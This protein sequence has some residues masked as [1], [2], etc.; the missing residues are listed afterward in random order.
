MTLERIT[1]DMVWDEHDHR[2]RYH[3][4]AGLI[5]PND[6]V[7]DAAC[8]I[9]YGTSILA[10]RSR[11]AYFVGVDKVD[12]D[13]EFEGPH[14][15]FVLADLESD[16]RNVAVDLAGEFDVSVSFETIEHLRDPA[17]FIA[18]L[19]SVTTRTIVAS[20]PVVPSKHWNEHH[21]HDFERN[22]LPELFAVNGWECVSIL[23]QPSES[24]SIYVFGRF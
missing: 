23:D 17:S 24:S 19:C 21:L 14:R 5:G 9:G 11:G 16:D 4:A 3:L 6:A 18:W 7:L 22:D 10:K 12:N 20:V 13:P 8:G 2:L 15:C 1:P